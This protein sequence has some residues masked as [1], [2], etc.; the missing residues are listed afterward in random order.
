MPPRPPLA[1]VDAPRLRRLARL[2]AGLLAGR[3]LHH[4]GP[5]HHPRPAATG[6]DFIDHRDF[7]AGDDPRGIDWRASARRRTPVVRRFRDERAGDWLIL[8][9]R[10]A[11]MAAGGAWPPALQLAAALAFVPMQLGHRTRVALFSGTVDAMSSG[12]RGEA[13]YFAQRGLLQAAVPRAGGGASRPEAC[14]PLIDRGQRIVLITDALRED[15]MLPALAR[16]A[17]AGGGLELLQVAAAPPALDGPVVAIDCE[18]GA[19]LRLEADAG[20]RTAAT[21]AQARL[22][23]RLEAG[24]RHLGVPLTR[25]EPGEPWDQVVVRHL[26]RRPRPLPPESPSG[27]TA[28]RPTAPDT[29]P[30]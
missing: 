22:N 14:V 28:A 17:A 16:L 2:V 1:D 20:A 27:E 8:L 23:T 30:A 10:S 21:E 13:A 5:L 25:V 19:S 3:P 26:L 11:S 12:G 4:G 15:A 9:D 18:S 29:A 24:C 6:L 7:I